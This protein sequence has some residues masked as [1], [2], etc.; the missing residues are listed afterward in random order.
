[1]SM[2]SYTKLCVSK[3]AQEARTPEAMHVLLDALFFRGRRFFDP[4]PHAPTFD[5]LNVPWKRLNYAN[6]PWCQAPKWLEKA[7][8][9]AKSGRSTLVLMPA[10][11][12]TDYLSKAVTSGAVTALHFWVNRITFLPFDAPLSL[13][14]IT[15]CYG[16]KWSPP[17][18]IPGR[19]SPL[20]VRRVGSDMWD[21]GPSADVAALSRCARAAFGPKVKTCSKVSCLLPEGTTLIQ[22]REHFAAGMESVARHVRLHPSAVVLLGTMSVFHSRYIL[23]H[24]DLIRG[25]IAFHPRVHI[26]SVEM[27][28][29]GQVLVMGAKAVRFR[30]L[31]KMP[32]TY[33]V[34]GSPHAVSDRDLSA[35]SS[36]TSDAATRAR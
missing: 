2:G 7:E 23:E 12:H 19:P 17:P 20:T 33:I 35:A 15:L 36:A 32:P 22:L 30:P 11:L 34:Q 5:G 6:M 1:M 13:S 27:I 21:I 10:R 9:E 26:G 8:R 28:A 3:E 25:I 29:G 16:D 31:A 14:I 18:K 4:C 24:V